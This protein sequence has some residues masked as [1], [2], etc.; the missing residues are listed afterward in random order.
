M[1]SGLTWRLQWEMGPE[2]L[3]YLDKLATTR[4]H[5]AQRFTALGLGPTKTAGCEAES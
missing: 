1:Q 3:E 5:D 2:G 4:V